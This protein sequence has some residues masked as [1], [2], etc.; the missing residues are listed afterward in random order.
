MFDPMPAV[1]A[2]FEDDSTKRLFS[3]YP[4][5]ILFHP[6]EFIGLTEQE[7]HSLHQRKDTTY[8]RS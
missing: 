5:E 6:S 2:T 3:F 8:L 4:D 7:A 1:I